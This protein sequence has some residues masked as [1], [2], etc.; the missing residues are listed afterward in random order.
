MTIAQA[1]Y[2]CRDSV[3]RCTDEMRERG[4]PERH[5]RNYVAQPQNF[6]YRDHAH[7]RDKL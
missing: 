4:G 5:A 7:W 1:I 2:R 3:R 6:N